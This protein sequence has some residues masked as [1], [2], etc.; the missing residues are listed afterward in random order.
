MSHSLPLTMHLRPTFLTLFSSVTLA[1]QWLNR[2]RNLTISKLS[3][4]SL[5]LDNYTSPGF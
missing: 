5:T 3:L 1:F 4:S 2:P